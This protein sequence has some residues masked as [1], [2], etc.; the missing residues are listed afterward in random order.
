MLNGDDVNKFLSF[1]KTCTPKNHKN[2]IP[3]L[4]D[5]NPTKGKHNKIFIKTF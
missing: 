5:I 2:K 4:L 1:E 3:E